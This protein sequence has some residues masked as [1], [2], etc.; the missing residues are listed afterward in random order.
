MVSDFIKYEN[1]STQSPRREVSST[2]LSLSSPGGT[3][4]LRRAP[5]YQNCSRF[6][7]HCTIGILRPPPRLEGTDHV[8]VHISLHNEW[9]P[10]VMCHLLNLRP[11]SPEL[12]HASGQ[13][14]PSTVRHTPKQRLFPE[15]HHFA[16]LFCLKPINEVLLGRRLSET[17]LSVHKHIFR[18]SVVHNPLLRVPMFLLPL[19][20][21]IHLVSI[22]WLRVGPLLTPCPVGLELEYRHSLCSLRTESTPT[23]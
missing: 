1:L 9:T 5:Q 13:R 2:E 6:A 10:F 20:A 19:S 17:H 14:T 7:T 11:V 15:N 4:H 21:Y 3:A 18:C 8:G 23:S 16:S 22:T 12:A